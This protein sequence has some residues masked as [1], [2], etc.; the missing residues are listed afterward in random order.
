[1]TR[2]LR[3]AALVSE[4]TGEQHRHSL[5]ESDHVTW[6]LASDWSETGEQHWA[7]RGEASWETG[8]SPGV[9]SGRFSEVLT[10]SNQ[11]I[12]FTTGQ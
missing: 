2:T 9:S 4:T 8:A 5:V 3:G 7:G 10:L 6:I 12:T 1:M 11:E